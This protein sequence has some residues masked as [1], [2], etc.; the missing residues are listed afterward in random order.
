MPPTP[1]NPASPASIRK[2][3]FGSVDGHEVD[4]Y[5]LTNTAGAAVAIM[6]YGAGIARLLVP[7]RHGTPADVV[8]GCNDLAGYR[9]ENL[10]LGVT[11]GRVAN[12]IR[13]ARFSLDG[14]AYTLAANDPPH[15]LHGGTRGWDKVVWQADAVASPEGPSVRLHRRSPDGEEGYPGNV[16]AEVI[17]TLDAATNLLRITMRA[18]TDRTTLC[19]MAHHSYFNLAGEGTGPIS[20]HELTLHASAYTPGDPLVPTGEIRAVAGT[21]FDFTRAKPI[22]R[23]LQ[24]TGGDP[25]GYDHNFIVDG[26]PDGARPVARVR[27]PRSGRVMTVEADQPAVQFY[28]G[29]F[30]NG[31]VVGKGGQP[32]RQHAGLCLETQRIPD[33]INIPAWREQVILRPGQVYAHNMI[34]RFTTE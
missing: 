19:N 4:V 20:D 12:R 24:A 21:P 7:D 23:D 6:T 26:A 16:D 8:L 2:T 17:Y 28:T 11:A 34:I 25:V 10:F 32:Y 1:S 22:G 5:T 33:A 13:N 29:N 18:T 30:L 27:D 3:P 31:A 9:K 14:Q 15:H